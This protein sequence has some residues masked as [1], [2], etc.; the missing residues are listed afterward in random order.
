MDVRWKEKRLYRRRNFCGRHT[1]SFS[2]TC[3][4]TLTTTSP[5]TIPMQPQTGLKASASPT[6]GYRIS[7]PPHRPFVQTW[8][9]CKVRR[10]CRKHYSVASLNLH[11]S[12]S[13]LALQTEQKHDFDIK[14]YLESGEPQNLILTLI[15]IDQGCESWRNHSEFAY[16]AGFEIKLLEQCKVF[17][18]LMVRH[19]YR[20][21]WY[22]IKSQSTC[23]AIN[24]N[25]SRI[26]YET[27]VTLGAK[28]I[29]PPA[30]SEMRDRRRR[31]GSF[32]WNYLSMDSTGLI[33]QT[34]HEIWTLLPPRCISQK[35]KSP[36]YE[37]C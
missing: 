11:V 9:F 26:C 8:I 14:I 1:A 3:T 5:L 34:L 22:R 2:S 29:L 27:G 37:S 24:A 32:R 10:L 13:S 25:K 35:R 30:R 4:N 6:P 12:S 7:H 16:N 15:L 36:Q 18:N 28:Y 20:I 21:D 19:L 31:G 23:R 33:P 17:W